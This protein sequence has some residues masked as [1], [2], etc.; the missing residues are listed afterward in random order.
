MILENTANSVEILNDKD[1]TEQS[2]VGNNSICVTTTGSLNSKEH[3]DKTGLSVSNFDKWGGA[4]ENISVEDIVWSACIN[5][6]AESGRNDQTTDTWIQWLEIESSKVGKTLQGLYDE[7]LADDSLIGTGLERLIQY[8]D[9][10]KRDIKPIRKE[11]YEAGYSLEHEDWRR[12]KISLGMK[13]SRLNESDEKKCKRIQKYITTKENWS[14]EQWDAVYGSESVRNVNI[15]YRR[16]KFLATHT[17][18]AQ[19][20]I[21]RF[22][23]AP[24][25]TSNK[26]N[27]VEKNVI[28]LSTALQYTG[29]GAYFVTLTKENGDIWHKNPDFI[30]KPACK[31]R[32][33]YVV[34]I[35]DFEYWHTQEEAK[36]VVDLYN[37]VGIYCLVIDAKRCYTEED[38]NSVK[39]EIN[40]FLSI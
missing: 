22:I 26:P 13:K 15:A 25:H 2:Q 1:H 7:L 5:K 40:A 35:M 16:K 32:A 30:F 37:K 3:G 38:L 28:K 33:K 23:N 4:T 31:R 14:D 36:L 17:D 18:A 20:Q 10:C 24:K 27:I 8:F 21:N 39:M 11:M 19:T 6:D 29:D 12:A 34:E 9:C